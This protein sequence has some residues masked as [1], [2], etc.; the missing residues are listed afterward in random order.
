[1]RAAFC[2]YVNEFSANELLYNPGNS[3][4]ESRRLSW[5]KDLVGARV[6]FSNEMRL[7][8]TATADGNLIK[9]I[10]SGGDQ[11]KVRG[12]FENGTDIVNRVTCFALANDFVKVTPPIATC[13]GL[14][15]R[16]RFS[17]YTKQFVETP[18][19][20]HERLKNPE[21]KNLF[22]TTA[23]KDA[24]F[25]VIWRCWAA[26]EESE[27]K[28]DGDLKTPA[29][30]K[31]ETKEWATGGD[32]SLREVLEKQYEITDVFG[33]VVLTK[34]VVEFVLENK[35]KMSKTKIGIDVR[36]MI[37]TREWDADQKKKVLE[38]RSGNKNVYHGMRLK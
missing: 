28:L 19:G 29:A 8:G 31:A 30:V 37:Q 14:Q 13:T 22:K 3:Q 4:D 32:D 10:S 27:R 15:E 25:Y 11:H 16:M 21:I 33:D 6:A 17:R 38:I 2:G 34:D 9:A 5:L 23:W 12:N 18:S 20:P 1:M 36:K 35:V 26:M 7:V 24:L